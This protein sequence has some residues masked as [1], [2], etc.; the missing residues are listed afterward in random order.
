M[1]RLEAA[2]SLEGQVPEKPIERFGQEAL[3][4]EEIQDIKVTIRETFNSGEDLGVYR[5]I[6]QLAQLKRAGVGGKMSLTEEKGGLAVKLNEQRSTLQQDPRTLA[7]YL[8][9]LKYL[10][11][12]EKEGV[13]KVTDGEK[14]LIIQ[15]I[16]NR[17][18]SGEGL[19][20]ACIDAKSLGLAEEIPADALEKIK[21]QAEELSAGRGHMESVTHELR[22]LAQARKLLEGKGEEIKVAPNLKERAGL[23]LAAHQQGQGTDLYKS[24]RLEAYYVRVAGETLTPVEEIKSHHN[25]FID[26]TK[27]LTADPAKVGQYLSYLRTI[28]ENIQPAEQTVPEAPAAA[29]PEAPAVQ[30]T[31]HPPEPLASLASQEGGVGENEQEATIVTHRMEDPYILEGKDGIIMVAATDEGIGYKEVNEDAVV[32]AEDAVVVIDG[33]G[34]RENGKE[35]ALAVAQTGQKV[36]QRNGSLDEIPLQARQLMQERNLGEGEAVMAAIRIK[37]GELE[38]LIVG[39][40][41]VVV[42]REGQVVDSTNDMGFPPPHNHRVISTI[43]AEKPGEIEVYPPFQLQEG[44][45]II[46]GSDGLL[47]SVASYVEVY[48][49]EFWQE[50][51]KRYQNDPSIKSIS[52]LAL[53]VLEEPDKDDTDNFIKE[54]LRELRRKVGRDDQELKGLE[55]GV[56][57]RQ[58]EKI[59]ALVANKGCVEAFQALE[60]RSRSNM[61]S[62]KGKPDNRSLVVIEYRPKSEIAV[63]SEVIHDVP[64]LSDEDYR[65]FEASYRD[66]DEREIMEE[67]KIN[68]DKL[69]QAAVQDLNEP[70]EKKLRQPNFY[71]EGLAESNDQL[72][73]IVESLRRGKSSAKSKK[74]FDEKINKALNH[75]DD[76]GRKSENP[77][78][79]SNNE[80]EEETISESMLELL[81]RQHLLLRALTMRKSQ[82]T[83][84]R[85]PEKQV[86]A[87][88]KNKP[89]R[90][91]K[92]ELLE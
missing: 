84:T 72:G 29:T 74:K 85:E 27:E 62:K 56:A 5:A 66:M 12:L 36:L 64:G 44:D 21:E 65:D 89:Q 57:R 87:R 60:A 83:Q 13:A 2:P 53:S 1:T 59:A 32:V 40:A 81:Q 54:Y 26:Y 41:R 25:D 3:S 34:G 86:R 79:L 55:V 46:V 49:K 8:V 33:V 11:L 91:N 63:P 61:A 78:I 39:D 76:L 7:K 90:G 22:F 48:N 20:G 70:A 23:E 19:A 67:W 71:V 52:V 82:E 38:K 14:E 43:S 92:R 47:E 50:I 4:V 10:G 37:N 51:G 35:A 73:E 30:A 17:K 42:V 16:F 28:E 31:I 75:I 45:K 6:D 15:D 24:A 80:R 69:D 88:G 9:R 58:N 18:N 77:D 68:Q